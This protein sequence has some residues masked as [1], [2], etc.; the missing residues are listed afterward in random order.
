MDSV[1]LSLSTRFTW[2]ICYKSLFKTSF[3]FIKIDIIVL[4]LRDKPFQKF[5]LNIIDGIITKIKCLTNSI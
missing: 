3:I 4:S 1:D 2:T 5:L